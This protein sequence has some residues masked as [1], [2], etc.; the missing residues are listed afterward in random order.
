MAEDKEARLHHRE[1]Q[2]RQ[3][4]AQQ[5]PIGVALP[6]KFE[7]GDIVSWLDSIDVCA[8]VNNWNNDAR[9]RHLPPLPEW[10]PLADFQRLHKDQ[11]DRMAHL[12]D[13]HIEVFANRLESLL[14]Q[15]L[16][17]LDGDASDAMLKQR[18]LRVMTPTIR[19]RL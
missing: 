11:T 6:T 8:T 1:E 3:A 15:E 9:L 17:D 13:S 14:R 10:R 4:I 16:P 12:R 5:Q 2:L 7:D 18:F 19:L